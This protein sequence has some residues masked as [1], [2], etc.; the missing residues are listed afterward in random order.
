MGPR[1][2]KG[3]LELTS[4][5]CRVDTSQLSSSRNYFSRTSRTLSRRFGR[6]NREVTDERRG[7]GAAV[8]EW[9]EKLTQ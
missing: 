2:G 3:K 9:R 1:S 4:L 6:R 8:S 5:A 7:L